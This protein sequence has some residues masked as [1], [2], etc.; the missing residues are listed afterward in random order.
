MV[1]V[2]TAWPE[3]QGFSST[4]A[5]TVWFPR[6]RTILVTMKT[7]RKIQQKPLKGIVREWTWVSTAG[8]N[9]ACH[10]CEESLAAL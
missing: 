9:T 6:L 10:T 2:G 5:N 4:A 8:H 7:L 1:A 3:G